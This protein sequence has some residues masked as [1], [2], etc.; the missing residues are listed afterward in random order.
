MSFVWVAVEVIAWVAFGFVL[1]IGLA[2][3]G[4]GQRGGPPED[5]GE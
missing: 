3:L 5:G 2:A 1:L 4:Y